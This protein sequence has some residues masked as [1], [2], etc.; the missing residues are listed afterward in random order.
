MDAYLM[1]NLLVRELTQ[2]LFR[3]DDAVFVILYCINHIV[4]RD[5][6]FYNIIAR[7]AL[8][9]L[10]RIYHILQPLKV[11]LL[12]LLV[13]VRSKFCSLYL[14]KLIYVQNGCCTGTPTGNNLCPEFSLL[15][16]MRHVKT[17][18]KIDFLAS[19]S[20]KRVLNLDA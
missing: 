11:I 4:I 2:R 13:A 5:T 19:N 7:L 3:R 20:Y 15:S 12:E 17:L 6:S 1:I 18:P 10:A 9:T 16:N 8:T 14:I